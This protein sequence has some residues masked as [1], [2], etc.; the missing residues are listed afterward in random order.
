M[1]L[2]E[3]SVQISRHASAVKNVR[4]HKHTHVWCLAFP[5][6]EKYTAARP[7]CLFKSG[8]LIVLITLLRDYWRKL[9]PNFSP[10][11]CWPTCVRLVPA[12]SESFSFFYSAA[13]M[14]K[15][16]QR[17]NTKVAL[18]VLKCVNWT[19]TR[20]AVVITR[21]RAFPTA[22]LHTCCPFKMYSQWKGFPRIL[23]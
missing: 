19:E 16:A 5:Q 15:I 6:S 21:Q 7:K 8:G 12:L 4:S 22:G 1:W 10:L 18:S 23:T 2:K 14:S 3:T 11:T 13:I 17:Q 9:K 20:A